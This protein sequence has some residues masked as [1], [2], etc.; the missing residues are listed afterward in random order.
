MPHDVALWIDHRQAVIAA[1][2]EDSENL[3]RLESGLEK[4]VR[5]SGGEGGAE[6]S[7]DKRFEGHL[8]QYYDRVVASVREARSIL[9]LGPGE[10]KHELEKR[11]RDAG[12]GGTIVGIETA[13]KMTD[14]QVAASARRRFRE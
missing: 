9:I 7:R 12:L 1:V 11:L 10:A 3:T 8:H 6:D 2:A 4:H 5:F 13:D 14:A